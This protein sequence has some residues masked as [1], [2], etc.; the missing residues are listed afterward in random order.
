MLRRTFKNRCCFENTLL[1]TA[2]QENIPFTRGALCSF[3][4]GQ[5]GESSFK[6]FQHLCRLDNIAQYSFAR[7]FKVIYK[8][9]N[10]NVLFDV[11]IGLTRM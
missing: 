11:F 3:V 8:K 6:K 7:L 4:L 1:G 5:P 2:I 10:V 9:R